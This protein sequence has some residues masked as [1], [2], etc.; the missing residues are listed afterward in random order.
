MAVEKPRAKVLHLV[1][2]R[3]V[4]CSGQIDGDLLSNGGQCVVHH[5]NGDGIN[6]NGIK[7]G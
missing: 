5:L 3:V 7:D 2:D 4:G 1:D 6:V